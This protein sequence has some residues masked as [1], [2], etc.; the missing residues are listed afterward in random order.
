MCIHSLTHPSIN[1]RVFPPSPRPTYSSGLKYANFI[2][3]YGNVLEGSAEKGTCMFIS[4]HENAGR[5]YNLFLFC[6]CV[7]T[8]LV[9]YYI[10][11]MFVYCFIF[12][13][14][15]LCILCFCIILCTVSP[16]VYTCLFPIFVQVCRP[17]SAGGNPIAVHKFI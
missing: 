14:S 2:R 4:R 1:P 9:F 13:F 15:I 5:N 17:L 12:L 10:L 3:Q 6:Y 16:F 11:F 8:R 7:I